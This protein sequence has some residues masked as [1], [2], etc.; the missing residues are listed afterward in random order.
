M[1]FFGLLG[2]L[3]FGLGFMS[4][5]LIG[6]MKIYR[7]SNHLP[8]ILVTNNPYFYIALT[9]IILGT[10][11]FLVGFLAELI[12]QNNPRRSVYKVESR[13]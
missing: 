3:L 10:M 12:N 7:L 9:T 1:H 8:T 2:T 11:L 13:V 5:L 4:I 6:G